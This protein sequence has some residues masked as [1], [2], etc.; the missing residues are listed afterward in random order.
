M[1]IVFFGT[2]DYVLPVLQKL[3]KTYGAGKDG[4]CA[5]VTQPPKE[6]GRKKFIERSAVDNWGYRHKLPVIYSLDQIPEADFA[7]VAA[8]GKIIPDTV[9]RKFGNGILNIHPSL[10]PKYRGASPIQAAIAAGETQIGVSIIKMDEQMD[11]G[12]IVTQFKDEITKEDTNESLRTRLFERSAQVL[13]DLMPN[14]LAKKINLKE[15]DHTKAT[16]T[17][18]LNKESGYISSGA[19]KEALEGGTLEGGLEVSFVKDLKIDATGPSVFNFL[20]SITPW[21]GGW[22]QVQIGENKLRLK[23]LQAHLEDEKLILDEVQLEGKNP[24]S[25]KQF[26]EGYPNIAL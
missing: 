1:K 18:L 6:A 26:K 22:T 23:I 19:L 13:V 15:Q 20:R 24:V 4:L 3:Y 2:P 10:L 9:I 17:K 16:F 14:Y 8:Y 25:W 5:V 7:V 21:P 11:H 12:P